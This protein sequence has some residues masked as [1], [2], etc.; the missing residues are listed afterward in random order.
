MSLPT[1]VFLTTQSTPVTRA[2]SHGCFGEGANYGAGNHS[3][4]WL[5]A[6]GRAALL[7]RA[8]CT[9]CLAAPPLATCAPA[10][11]CGLEHR[12][13]P[14]G[15][16]AQ[17]SH[18]LSVRYRRVNRSPGVDEEGRGDGLRSC[19]EGGNVLRRDGYEP[20]F[21]HLCRHDRVGDLAEP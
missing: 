8:S 18:P 12:L 5:C 20:R 21:Y 15:G 1:P 19:G 2:A 3:S 7:T 14:S 4:P 9:S 13:G 17:C 16:E 6:R 11:A 10:H